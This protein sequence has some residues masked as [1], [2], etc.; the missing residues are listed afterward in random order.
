MIQ[1]RNKKLWNKKKEVAS[2]KF[3]QNVKTRNNKF[4]LSN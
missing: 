1:N 2:K 3:Y 4:Q